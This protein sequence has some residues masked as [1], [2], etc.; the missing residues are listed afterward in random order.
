MLFPDGDD[1]PVPGALAALDAR[2]AETG[3][4]DVLHVE[5]ERAPWWEGGPGNPAAP[6]PARA[7]DGVFSPDRAP[8]LTGV[9]LPVWSAAW[10][11]ASVSE[12]DDGDAPDDRGAAAGAGRAAAA[13]AGGA[14]GGGPGAGGSGGAG[15]LNPGPLASLD[16][17]M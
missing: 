16:E 2:L 10:R 3:P 13:G 6:L 5:H 1:V 17:V 15:A 4:V 7:P 11:R 14:A 8:H 9:G 12:R